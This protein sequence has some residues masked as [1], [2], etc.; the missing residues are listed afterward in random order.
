[1]TYAIDIMDDL[2]LKPLPSHLQGRV[3]ARHTFWLPDEATALYARAK[4]VVS[5]ECHSPL[6]AYTQGVPAIYLRQPTDTIKGQMY[7]DI[8]LP[9]WI[10]EIEQAGEAE[11]AA[12]IFKILVEPDWAK[13]YLASAMAYVNERFATACER[14][15][16][17]ATAPVMT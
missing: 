9:E 16:D 17:I 2:L 11:I 1:M 14:I 13:N 8:G 10:L 7:R 15:R 12:A 6:L 4:A 3:L 5:L